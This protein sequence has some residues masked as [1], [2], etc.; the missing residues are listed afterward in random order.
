LGPVIEDVN[1]KSGKGRKLT[2]DSGGKKKGFSGEKNPV[3]GQNHGS[4]G[5]EGK[6]HIKEV[7]KRRGGGPGN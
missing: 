7:E 2:L 4:L 1:L 3:R 6:V 5:E